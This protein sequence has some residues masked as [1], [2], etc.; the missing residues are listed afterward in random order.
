[1]PVMSW[2]A[3]YRKPVRQVGPKVLISSTINAAAIGVLVGLLVNWLRAVPWANSAAPAWVQAVGSILAILVAV[4][5]ASWTSWTQR[6]ER[7][8]LVF[9]E[10]KKNW[11]AA[12][13]ITIRVKDFGVEY[14]QWTKDASGAS[15]KT[16]EHYAHTVDFLLAALEQ[17]LQRDRDF[18]RWFGCMQLH[19]E[20][21]DF[22]SMLNSLDKGAALLADQAGLLVAEAEAYQDAWVESLDTWLSLHASM[23]T[24]TE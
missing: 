12:I 15:W 9:V 8:H 21:R 3:I 16:H 20:L 6:R 14:E 13:Q 1:M 19:E 10:E 24:G 23:G 7:R 18:D 2:S 22:R 4:G 11:Q 17:M 5:V